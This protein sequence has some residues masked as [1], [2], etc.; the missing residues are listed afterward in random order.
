M[1]YDWYEE[2]FAAFLLKYDLP[3][4]NREYEIK[5]YYHNMAC[6]CL[7][8]YDT[9]LSIHKNR[10]HSDTFYDAL[11]VAKSDVSDHFARIEK[12]LKLHDASDYKQA[13]EI[14]D[15][16]MEELKNEILIR[17]INGISP[18]NPRLYRV[19]AVSDNEKLTKPNDL[20]HIPYTKRQ[21]VSNERYSLAGYPCLYLATYLGIAW[22]ECGYPSKFYYS[23][24]EYQYESDQNNEWKFI[25]FLSPRQVAQGLLV[26][27]NKDKDDFRKTFFSSYMKTYP[28]MLACS[29]VNLS[30]DS[31]FKPEFIIP[32]MLLQ[33]VR[34]NIRT[35]RGITYFSCMDNDDLRRING[36][37]IVIPAVRFNK[38]GYCLD[39]TKK[40]KISKPMFCNNLIKKSEHE[41][42]VAFKNDIKEN[43]NKFTFEAHECVIAMYD[44][45]NY[46][47]NLLIRT[48]KTD[49]KLV[50]ET[51][52]S[53][54][55][56]CSYISIKYKKDDIIKKARTGTQRAD[57]NDRISLFEQYY[58]RFFTDV[59]PV[60]SRYKFDIEKI[61]APESP[62]F[63]VVR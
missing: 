53:I 33:W 17:T 5:E 11:E 39:L 13:Q 57:E 4:Y 15:E 26:A 38:K 24:F 44:V 47:D 31:T 9:M 29:I 60:I 7:N 8:D 14:F 62:A 35:I 36:Y 63:Y 25:T 46:F 61:T 2:D 43:I 49:M 34:R 55:M 27:L 56:N 1:P 23:E 21:L 54:L 42:I 19:R 10:S 18:Y 12:V 48:E 40:F 59:E 58:D 32:Q 45:C 28:L 22:Q 52:K 20:S 37:N 30:G 6:N 50:V 41:K 16:M 51:I 3:V